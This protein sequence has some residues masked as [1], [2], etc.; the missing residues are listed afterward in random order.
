MLK[1]RLT[2]ICQGVY[3]KS[4][5]MTLLLSWATLSNSWAQMAGAIFRD[6]FERNTLGEAWFAPYSWSV[7]GGA[8]YN[9]IDGTGGILK[10][11][12]YFNDSSYVLETSGRGF[13]RNYYRE[14]RITF[15]QT[16]LTS[17]SGYALNY[18]PYSGG[19]LTLS[20]VTDNIYF[21]EILDG[22]T[23][24]P[25]LETDKY[26]QFKIARYKSGL[27]QV[28]V[29]KGDGYGTTP[30]LEAIDRT[31]AQLGHFGWQIDTQT[32][33]EEFFVDY[34]SVDRPEVEKPAQPEK[35]TEDNLIAQ[36]TATSG[37]SHRVNKLKAGEKPYS[38]REYTV[39]E[40]PRYL[41]GASFIQMAMNDKYDTTQAALSFILK[42]EVILYVAYD[43]RGNKI[44]A[45]LNGWKKTGDVI[46][47]TDP[48]SK[49]L[50]V[51]SRLMEYS[52]MS[53]NAVVLGGNLARPAAGAQI[54][55]LVAAVERPTVITLEA[56]EAVLVGPQ[57]AT[58][59][60][61]YSGAGF[62]DYR[63]P[64]T[65]YIEWQVDILTPGDYNLGF[66]YS[67]ANTPS[68]I[69]L[70]SV[71]GAAVDS[72]EFMTTSNW[73]NWSFHGGATVYLSSGTHTIRA[74]AIGTSG[75][76]LDLLQLSYMSPGTDV[77]PAP[78]VLNRTAAPSLEKGTDLSGQP[79]RVYP[80]PITENT[81]IAYSLNEPARVNLAVYTTQGQSLQVLVNENQGA[82]NH[83]AKLDGASLAPGIYIYRLQ[84][85]NQ[86]KV[87]K[88][89]KR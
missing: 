32:F 87:G 57:T 40:V 58:N 52:G 78:I 21:G 85:N 48:G 9:Y 74:T 6:D 20:R 14:F 44:P 27:I 8:A 75:P 66:V 51:Y 88:I 63:N 3:F 18:T 65:D 10:T 70:V 19:R 15:G 49:Y 41:E 47:T 77:A 79:H 7:S 13:T 23:L 86:L 84:T 89:V 26:Y 55:Y 31:Y 39:T 50:E 81:R 56:E 16:G 43:Q 46:R 67:I 25:D 71:D 62:V 38:D 45:W 34:I 2:L 54:N 33:P 69:L 60:P 11:T 64:T 80:N 29:N 17:D 61:G 35:P 28:Y 68:R 36:V 82:G 73:E 5:V 53:S 24:F 42:K 37:R 4:L 12:T 72:A 1:T 30:V 76:N 83:E 22:V 59:H